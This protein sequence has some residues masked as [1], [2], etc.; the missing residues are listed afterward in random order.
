VTHADR[1]ASRRLGRAVWPLL[2]LGVGCSLTINM[3]EL[4]DGC[5]TG[6]KDCDGECLAECP[7]ENGGSSGSGGESGTTMGKGGKGGSTGGTTTSEG[8]AAGSGPCTA[9]VAFHYKPQTAVSK[10]HVTG[11]FTD[12]V[13]P[14]YPHDEPWAEWHEPGVPMEDDGTGVY[15][16]VVDMPA[17]RSLYKFIL[18][19]EGENTGTWV[20]DP[21]NPNT[22]PDNFTSKNSVL[23]L[24]CGQ[25]YGEGGAGG[26]GGSAGESSGGAG[27]ATTGVGG[28]AGAGGI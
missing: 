14:D 13:Y 28:A 8:G 20:Y 12:F 11:D 6:L 5:G 1:R 24:E 19:W 22:V 18:D 27:G 23:T 3:N 25:T 9:T 26:M 10:V 2:F 16:A 15:R 7:G 21:S 4:S 17:G